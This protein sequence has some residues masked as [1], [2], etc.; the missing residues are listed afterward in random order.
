MRLSLLLATLLVPAAAFVAP[1]RSTVRSNGRVSPCYYTDIA[2]EEQRQ[3]LKNKLP[4]VN[5]LRM[6][7]LELEFRDLLEGILYT[8]QEIDAMTNTRLR[9]IYEGIEASY[10]ERAV[11]RAF[12]VLYEDYIPLRIA[13]RMIYR[14]MT[15]VME[16]SKKY[17]KEQVQAVLAA[18][19][20]SRTQVQS[21]WSVFV[22]LAE[23]REIST[24]KVRSHVAERVVDMLNY[25]DVEEVLK[26]LDPKQK[27][28]LSFQELMVGLHRCAVESSNSDPANTLQ[29]ILTFDLIDAKAMSN[30]DEQRMKYNRRYDEMLENFAVWKD[31]IP[32][33]EGR[34]IDIMRGCF[35]GSENPKVVEALRVVYVDFPPLRL[36]GDWIFKVV[37]SIMGRRGKN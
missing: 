23:D 17:R 25:D 2:V 35:V 16:E 20:L 21:C 33:G 22:Q 6:S 26:R 13:G 27:G 9:V 30:I 15:T 1:V 28:R 7:K 8:P 3:E 31:F 11:Y 37:S 29:E 19:N 5:R 36:S 34:R 32:S 10:N 12:E 14:K 4:P 18:T 24:R